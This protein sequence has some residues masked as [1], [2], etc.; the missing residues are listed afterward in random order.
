MIALKTIKPL[1]E[2]TIYTRISCAPDANASQ[3]DF[4]NICAHMCVRIHTYLP[5]IFIPTREN[6]VSRNEI[7]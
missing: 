5:G 6:N 1:R 3:R 4:S 7:L 2:S